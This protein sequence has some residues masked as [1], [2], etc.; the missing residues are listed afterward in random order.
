MVRAQLPYELNGEHDQ[1]HSKQCDHAAKA[2]MMT[3]STTCLTR[4]SLVRL[5]AISLAWNLPGVTSTR[6]PDAV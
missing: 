4:F 2:V 3:G 5:S 6:L 1:H